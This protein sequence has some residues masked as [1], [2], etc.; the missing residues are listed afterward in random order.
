MQMTHDVFPL[1]CPA[2][3]KR[4][5]LSLIVQKIMT[6]RLKCCFLYSS[7]TLT[8]CLQSL[9]MSFINGS[10]KT[11]M[12]MLACLGLDMRVVN[13]RYF[14][15]WHNHGGKY[16][17]AYNNWPGTL[18]VPHLSK[19]IHFIGAKTKSNIPWIIREVLLVTRE[20][21]ELDV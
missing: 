2:G 21:H 1:A 17:Y 20:D 10:K 15:S 4:A 18:W 12:S 5:G 11:S 13:K 8:S 19:K 9:C 7:H 16:V 14:R 6:F 3:A